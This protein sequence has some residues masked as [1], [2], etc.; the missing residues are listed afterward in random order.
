MN[1]KHTWV[2]RSQNFAS[3]GTNEFQLYYCEK[4]LAECMIE[5]PKGVRTLI[6]FTECKKE[7]GTCQ[8]T[9]KK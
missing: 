3:D 8:R 9:L 2:F 1:C 4:C 6:N 7:Q 5:F